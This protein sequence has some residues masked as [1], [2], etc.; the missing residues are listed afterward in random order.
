[1]IEVGGLDLTNQV[2]LNMG[3]RIIIIISIQIT[4]QRSVEFKYNSQSSTVEYHVSKM[5]TRV[6]LFGKALRTH[7]NQTTQLKA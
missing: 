2:I 7:I 6:A 4:R 1:M 5:P 3:E